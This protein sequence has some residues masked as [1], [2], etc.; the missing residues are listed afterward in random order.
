LKFICANQIKSE[1]THILSLWL[2]VGKQKAA[3]L[4]VVADKWHKVIHS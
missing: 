4:R 1:S 2:R 3:G